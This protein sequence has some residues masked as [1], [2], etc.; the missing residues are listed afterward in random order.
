MFSLKTH[1]VYQEIQLE[2]GINRM[3]Y[4]ARLYTR[5][6]EEKEKIFGT[7]LDRK[8]AIAEACSE[9]HKQFDNKYPKHRTYYEG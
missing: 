9:L 4:V 2:D 8:T 1:D 5:S 7:A 6:G 3:C